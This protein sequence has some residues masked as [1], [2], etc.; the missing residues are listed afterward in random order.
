MIWPR[1]KDSRSPRGRRRVRPQTRER[2]LDA[3]ELPAEKLGEAALLAGLARVRLASKAEVLAARQDWPKARDIL[4]QADRAGV[5][6]EDRRSL[7]YALGIAGFHT[8]DELGRVIMR[9]EQGVDKADNKVQGYDLITQACLRMQ[10][11]DLNKALEANRKLRDVTEATEEEQTLAK[12]TGGEILLR[13]VSLTRPGFLWEKSPTPRQH[14]S[15][16]SSF[17]VC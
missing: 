5:T 4:E 16:S 14:R 1:A 6:D 7:L 12:L 15:S 9:L 13:L 10:P 17:A 2:C 3:S 8:G 11:P